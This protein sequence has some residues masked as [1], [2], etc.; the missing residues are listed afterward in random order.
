MQITE[1]QAGWELDERIAAILGWH[2]IQRRKWI[3]GKPQPDPYGLPTGVDPE[4][5]NIRVIDDYSSAIEAAWQ[6]V[7]PT[8]RHPNWHW[9]IRRWGSVWEVSLD[10]DEREWWHADSES[11][12]LAICRAALAALE[13]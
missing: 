3:D 11:A 7:E 13:R 5:G 9:K 4:D 1:L 2:D 6:I 8:E 12:P 10:D